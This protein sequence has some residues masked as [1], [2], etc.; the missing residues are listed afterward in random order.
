MNIREWL[1]QRW[2]PWWLPSGERSD[3]KF[4]LGDTTAKNKLA[5]RNWRKNWRWALL[6]RGV[7]EP[8][9]P[10]FTS[11]GFPRAYAWRHL[12]PVTTDIIAVRVG[13]EGVD[14]S[15]VPI[16]GEP[17]APEHFRGDDTLY[18]RQEAQRVADETGASITFI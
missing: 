11:V 3:Y 13:P 16:G 14:F 6:S 15:F 17:F 9:F 1:Q 10:Y 5:D 2:H 18:S 12:L 4:L 7:R 8:V